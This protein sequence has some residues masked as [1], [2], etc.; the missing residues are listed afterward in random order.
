MVVGLIVEELTAHEV[1]DKNENIAQYRAYNS[2]H[3]N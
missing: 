3:I 1:I 2:N